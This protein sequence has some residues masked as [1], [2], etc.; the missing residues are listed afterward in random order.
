MS[1]TIAAQSASSTHWPKQSAPG[2]VSQSSCWIMPHTSPKPH[3][4]E[5]FSQAASHGVPTP[6]LPPLP[7]DDDD[8][9]ELLELLGPLELLLLLLLLLLEDPA[10]PAPVELAEPMGTFSASLPQA[11][12]ADA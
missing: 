3:S 2:D 7:D 10:A 1:E 12:K 6:P 4:S 11:R 5:I 8:D 9:D